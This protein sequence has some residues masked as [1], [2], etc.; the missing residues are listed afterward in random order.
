MYTTTLL[1][2]LALATFAVARTDLAG[3]TSS[4]SGASLI[5]YV[6]GTG[7]I[8]KI[9]DCGGGRAPPKTTV[10]GCAAYVGTATYEPSYLPG[11]GPGGRVSTEAP[12]VTPTAA[13]SSGY[14][15]AS[16]T[17][18]VSSASSKAVESS[19][20]STLATIT[21]IA[22]LSSVPTLVGTGSSSLI[23]STG[24]NNVTSSVTLTRAPI[25]EST[26]A[27]DALKVVKQGLLGVVAGVV[28]L[29]ML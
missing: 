27:A 8:C 28:G 9:P 14:V 17:P 12:S 19:G 21:S 16:S 2:T 7:E 1:S 25:P 5:W 10:P 20:K 4:A 15:Q 13:G 6:P 22:H 26:G 11:W 23:H 18:A 29:A 24:G 3:C